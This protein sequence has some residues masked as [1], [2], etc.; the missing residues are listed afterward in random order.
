[1]RF[2]RRRHR[3]GY[4]AD[5]FVFNS[6]L[7]G[8]TNV[9]RVVDFTHNLDKLMLASAIFTRL[10]NAGGL[11]PDNFASNATGNAI[12][13]NDYLVYNSVTGVLTYDADGNGAGVAIAFANLAS[14]PALTAADF[15][16]V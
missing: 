11:N 3:A 9:D 12:D 10:Q 13:G 6:A 5:Q 7:N 14:H 15:T 8:S 2:P 1:M 16:V 4:G